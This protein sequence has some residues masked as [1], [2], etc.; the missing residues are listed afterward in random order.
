MNTIDK[1]MA[2]A[3]ALVVDSIH[4]ALAAHTGLRTEA[5]PGARKAALRAALAEALDLGEPVV[6]QYIWTNPPDMPG[7]SPE[8]LPVK[9]ERNQT[10]QQKVDEL[11]AYRYD[12]KPAY[13][14]RRLYAAKDATCVTTG[15]IE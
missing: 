5:S 6:H 2:L 7:Q 8:W 1:I 9:P 10:L 13:K 11:E 3:D 15:R 4:A 12:G 14:I